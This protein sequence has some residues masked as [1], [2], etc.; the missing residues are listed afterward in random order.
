MVLTALL[1]GKIHWSSRNLQALWGAF[2][3]TMRESLTPLL[4][5]ILN[6]VVLKKSAARSLT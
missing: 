5:L 1:K 2:L 4:D 6:M 3:L